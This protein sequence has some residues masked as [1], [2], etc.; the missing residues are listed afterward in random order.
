MSVYNPIRT[1]DTVPLAKAPERYVWK[2]TDISAKDAGRTEDMVTHK[3]RKGQALRLELEWRH[4]SHADAATILQAFNPEY[5]DVEFLDAKSG[6]WVTKEFYVG[7]RN[8]P[9]YNVKLGYW[10]SISFALIL[11]GGDA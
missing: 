9:S 10:E 2:L 5:V 7:D 3:M 6:T 4:V 1:V 11:R 8:A